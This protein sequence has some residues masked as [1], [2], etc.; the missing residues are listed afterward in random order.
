MKERGCPD[1][2]GGGEPKVK[3]TPKYKKNPNNRWTE[4]TDLRTGSGKK[5]LSHRTGSCVEELRR[6]QAALESKEGFLRDGDTKGK[7]NKRKAQKAS[8]K[9]LLSKIWGHSQRKKK[10]GKSMSPGVTLGKTA[11]RKGTSKTSGP[12]PTEKPPEKMQSP[13]LL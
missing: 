9:G 10:K 5:H 12:F 11:T 8:T 7:A 6:N 13:K 1:A 4:K 3:A 2:H